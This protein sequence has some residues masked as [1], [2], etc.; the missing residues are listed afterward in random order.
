MKPGRP[1]WLPVFLYAWPHAIVLVLLLGAI[2]WGLGWSTSTE[3]RAVA[4]ALAI[5]LSA[6]VTLILY[7]AR[8]YALIADLDEFWPRVHPVIVKHRIP[9]AVALN[10]GPGVWIGLT[11]NSPGMA[12]LATR[13]VIVLIGLL[14]KLRLD[15]LER[16]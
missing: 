16:R 2:A 5:W 6:N 3:V 13:L 11:S 12:A 1:R 14:N 7:F 9:I 4:G 10:A 8:R 15:Q